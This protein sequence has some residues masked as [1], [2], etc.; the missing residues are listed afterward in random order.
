MTRGK[1]DSLLHHPGVELVRLK[2]L[3]IKIRLI[4]TSGSFLGVSVVKNPP[5]MQEIQETWL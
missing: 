1:D 2:Y 3:L 4:S 5:A